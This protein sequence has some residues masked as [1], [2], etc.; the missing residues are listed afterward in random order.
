MTR[1][2]LIIVV[3]VAVIVCVPF[4]LLWTLNT[5]FALALP[6]NFS[7]WVAALVLGLV[8]GSCVSGKS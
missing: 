4:V 5:L 2:L 1:L 6:Y 7:T 8:L 3:C